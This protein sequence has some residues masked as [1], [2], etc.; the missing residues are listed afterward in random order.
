MA[1]SP[2]PAPSP[3]GA[4][5]AAALAAQRDAVTPMLLEYQSPS[6]ALIEQRVPAASR[7]TLWVLA[8]MFAVALVLMGT[9]P[10]DRVVVTQGKVVTTKSNIAIQPLET[11]IVRSIDVR[12]GQ[13]VKA[14]Q[15][16][17]RLDPTFA[18]ADADSLATQVASLQAEVDR[19]QAEV[20]GRGYVGDGSAPSQLQS[21]IFTQRN[22]ERSFRLE[23]FRQRIDAVRVRVA[24]A[25]A[26]VESYTVR[27]NV[28]RQ[29]EAMRVELERQA[30]GSR[31]NT[32]QALQDRNE[33]ARLLDAAR[34]QAVGSQREL[35]ALMAERDSYVQQTRNESSQ[36]LTE[37]GR[38]LSEAREN[39][40]KAR[41]RRDL[42]ELRADR[43]S[44]VLSVAP[45]SV[46][47]VMQSAEQFLMLVPLDAPLEIEAVVD[48]RDAGFVG[49]G[50]PV[51]I[52]FDTFPYAIY[53]T[54]EGRVQVVSPD[55]F[56][57]PN[58]DR[59]RQRGPRGSQDFGASYYRARMS[60][61]ALKL[62]NLPEGFRLS[63]GMPVTADIKIG[64]RTV[65]AYLFS[66]VVPV[67]TEGLREP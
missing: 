4:G 53:G 61:D 56:R 62:H 67:T 45:V 39:L 5:A 54:A 20:E 33:S 55:S 52:K 12:E 28:A 41:L 3:S 26:D 40:N 48:G 24:Q 50:D 2:S 7:Y 14:G 22:A 13:I 34:S 15:L 18:T 1:Q 60:I 10:I 16:L 57:N 38:R 63:P 64:Q 36:Q 32:F 9:V 42:V 6:A 17:A 8:S 37:Q 65:L 11:A 27:L 66:R 19:L 21:L 47:S 46:G 59:Q 43:D 58:E 49:S 30:V 29:V 35:E 51:T 23:N 31:L 25:M 44:I